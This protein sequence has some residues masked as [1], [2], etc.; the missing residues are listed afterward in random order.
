METT[1]DFDLA[2]RAIRPRIAVTPKEFGFL[3]YLALRRSDGSS[4]WVEIEE[5][6]RR[7][8]KWRGQ[9]PASAGKEVARI[10]EKDWFAEHVEADR[11]T[12]G[13]YRL[14][15]EV[16]FLPSRDAANE[17]VTNEPFVSSRL[18]KTEESRRRRLDW[19][20]LQAYDLLV[21]YGVYL[22]SLIDLIQQRVGDPDNIDGAAERL[23]ACKI[24]ATLHKNRSTPEVARAFAEKGLKL[25]RKL[26]KKDDVAYLLDQIGGTYH[27][28]DDDETAK[29]YF[30]E[31]IAYLKDWGTKRA[32]YHLVGAH[33][34]LAAAFRGLGD[35][36]SARA[37]MSE[38]R[39]YA[40]LSGNE[41]GARI[42]TV[43]EARLRQLAGEDPEPE[44]PFLGR[45]PAEHVIARVMALTTA[46]ANLLAQGVDDEGDR[47]L[48]V[49][50][51]DAA[52]LGLRHE[53]EKCDAI[54]ARFPRTGAPTGQ[55][56]TTSRR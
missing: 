52:R 29:K 26:D 33:R 28:G 12:L 6:A 31:E 9:A 30:E 3:L 19:T 5:I 10:A 2:E 44:G 42:A 37:S 55:R 14:I 46:A 13:P 41:E 54:A 21:Q 25:A 24:M 15:P 50:R 45:L 48:S 32:E 39:R 17:F 7:A 8:P 22:P 34:G 36:K 56:S 16:R 47:L 49:A 53:V 43:E 20:E 23:A 4:G 35:L 1:L 38:S 11:V 27:I 51:K 40:D 18:K